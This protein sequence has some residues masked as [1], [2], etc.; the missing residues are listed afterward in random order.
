MQNECTCIIDK[1]FKECI[2]FDFLT[3]FDLMIIGQGQ[4]Y[5]IRIGY[6]NPTTKGPKYRMNVLTL[7]IRF[8]RCEMVGIQN[9]LQFLLQ[10]ITW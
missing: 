2:N 10:F 1:I 7:L 9:N 3:K 4:V 5:H 6:S 8:L